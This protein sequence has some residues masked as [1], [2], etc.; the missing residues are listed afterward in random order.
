MTLLRSFLSVSGFVFASRLLGLVRDVV[1]AAVFGAGIATDAFFAAFRLPNTL[2]RFTAEGAL[3]QAFVP[4]YRQQY[5]EDADRAGRLA[6]E[7]LLF[8][9]LGLLMVSALCMLFAPQV[10]FLLAPGLEAAAL[11]ADLLRIVFPYIVLVSLVALFAGML[12]ACNYFSA[13]AAAPLF[14]NIAMII[15]A[16]VGAP[17]F[18]EPITALAWGVLA[19]GGLQFVWLLWH[20]RRAGLLPPLP[21]LTI[22]SAA[23]RRVFALFWRSALGAGVTQL[24][25]LINLV[26]ASFLVAGSISWL[27]YADRLMELP[28][29][30]LGAALT[31]VVLPSLAAHAAQ[32]EE[33]RRLLDNALRLLLLL[34]LPAAAGLAFLALPLVSTLFMYGAFDKT[35]VLMTQQAVFA[36]AVGVPGL[37][38][39]RPLAA[40][41]F[42]RQQAMLPVRA[43][44]AAL[45]A[46][47]SMNVLFIF[48]LELAHV[49]LALSVGLA[50]C[51]NALILYVMLRRRGW[52]AHLPGWGGFMLRVAAALLAMLA[53][54]V[55]L[56]PADAFW[57]SA[58]AG[59]RVGRLLLC[60]VGA[61]VVYFAVA[62][63][64]GLS[65]RQFNQPLPP[66]QSE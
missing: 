55:L 37:V 27:Y 29:G 26:I 36:Y 25:L 9:A 16:L 20:T 58:T 38:A 8:L 61:V 41:F 44:F 43:A 4:A 6:G 21:R 34:A 33:F 51:V 18:A 45:L 63:L 57:L 53:V 59:Q 14:L 22:P 3:T 17:R 13:A 62:W 1:I 54:L 35:D 11:A 49:G 32:P 56:T 24:N 31:T 12:N 66:R 28:A 65:W 30:L 46:A 39:V 60:L 23:L 50:A 19:G 52:Y 48:V 5:Q 7:A 15:F 42:A 64:T 47:Q 40:A 10:I 2:R